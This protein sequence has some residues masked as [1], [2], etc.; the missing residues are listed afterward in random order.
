MLASRYV[1]KWLRTR[2]RPELGFG[3]CKRAGDG[4]CG[5]AFVDVPDVSEYDL[6]VP[7]AD[8]VDEPIPAGTRIW[9]R[10]DPYGWHVGVI[11]SPTTADRYRVHLVGI[12]KPLP[13]YQDQFKVRW[14]RPLEDPTMAVAYGMT[15]AP[16]YYE[17]RSTLLGHFVR[18]RQVSRGLSAAISAPINLYQHQIDTAARVLAD[19]VMR[20]LLA[21]EV[22]LGKT[23]EAGLVIRQVLIDDARANVLVLCP[24]TLKGQWSAE[25]RDRLGLGDDL[26]HSRIR[27]ASHDDVH[28]LG[29]LDHFA[30][31]VVDEAHNLLRHVPPYSSVEEN[32][33]EVKALLALSAT[34]MRG[35]I[36]TFRRLLA[37]VDP[38][39]FGDATSEDFRARLEER[40]RNAGDIQVLAARRASMR[41]KST[42]LDSVL[43]DFPKDSNIA[44]LAQTCRES[45]DPK[46]PTWE[47]LADYVREIYRLSRRMI[48]HRRDDVLTESYAVAGRYPTF[49]EIRDPARPAID[50]FLEL[51]RFRLE[52]IDA[53][54]VFAQTV[55]HALAGPATFREFLVT[56]L[57][58]TKNALNGGVADD[59]A[60][61]ETTLA[62][63][64]IAGLDAR[65]EAA[66]ELVRDRVADGRKVVVASS[67]RSTAQRFEAVLRTALG[68]YRVYGHFSDMTA[69]RRDDAVTYFLGGR[70]GSVL[71][72]DASMEEGRNLQEA[73]TLVNLDIPLDANR[74][75]QRIGR[76]DRYAVR[77]YPAEVVVFTEA[78][79][80]WVSGQIQLLHEGIGVFENS[81]STVQR[82][83]TSVLEGVVES[84]VAKGVE[85]LQVDSIDLRNDL[86]DE[87]DTIDLLEELE[88]VSAATVFSD[89][90]FAE[91]LEY[92]E[93]TGDLRSAMW[94][95]TTGKGALA[96]KLAEASDGIVQF[97]SVKGIGLAAD[98]SAQLE[99]LLKPKAYNRAVALKQSG[100]SPF[101]IGD[102]LV[103]WLER[104]LVNDE[105]GRASAVI[106]PVTGLKTP[107]LWL[108]S[109]FL[110]EFDGSFS[111]VTDNA[112]RRRHVRRGEGL[113]PPVELETWTDPSGPASPQL[114]ADALDV[115]F[116]ESC[117]EVL[118]GRNWTG[119]LKAFPSWPHLCKESANAAR[120]LVADAQEFQDAVA[121]GL[122]L[123]EEDIARRIATLEA[124]ALRLATRT[125][126]EA[127]RK[128]LELERAMGQALLAGIGTPSVRM[129]ACGVVVLWPEGYAW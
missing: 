78:E 1:G 57:R 60:L 37:L 70:S 115:P 102:P 67:F 12:S 91:L 127:A 54:P 79:S 111:G 64:D 33:R 29:K 65:L 116:D 122:R 46:D 124:R 62:R 96:L 129:V 94:R 52:S 10:G 13:L 45:G 61:F 85:A 89:D 106:R 2:S 44:A 28:R 112:A 24:E 100:V 8:L 88:A 53:A 86:E 40:E 48:R 39:A 80:E 20:Y 104:Y 14:S 90:V 73:E 23:I 18:Q 16:T 35:D 56:K 51:Y 93:D 75:D 69:Q 38:V 77:S 66:L 109:E 76:L 97:G 5:L 31:V 128:E 120:E 19:P 43:A 123:A 126:R 3:F 98:E 83:L 84:L 95:L 55:L 105:R 72:A 125:E 41:Q 103:D 107:A 114:V 119:I 25:L 15:E 110:I 117:D 101:R 7:V 4:E 21:D 32:L 108:H 59:R 17:A 49:V 27:V 6:V 121:N 87:R 63:L 11:G 99:K 82:L 36:E 47:R 68:P 81:V 30:V 92:E 71:V 9:V 50:E 26:R 58:N 42:A 34:P 22:G 74:L 113:M 118:R